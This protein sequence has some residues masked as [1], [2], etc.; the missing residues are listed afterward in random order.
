[1]SPTAKQSEEDDGK[2]ISSSSKTTPGKLRPKR[3]ASAQKTD[4]VME[5]DQGKT[6]DA[7]KDDGD[8][9]DAQNITKIRHDLE[10]YTQLKQQVE[11]HPSQL[12]NFVYRDED[13]KLY[14]MDVNASSLRPPLLAKNTNGMLRNILDLTNVQVS[15]M[16]TFD[17]D[18]PRFFAV[19]LQVRIN[20]V[21]IFLRYHA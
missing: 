1:M 8:D 19:R 15:D 13:N 2:P 21:C 11:I 10:K 20:C 18:R 7:S 6:K 16:Q 5:I 14:T 4:E 9:N 12:Q 17:S 3:N